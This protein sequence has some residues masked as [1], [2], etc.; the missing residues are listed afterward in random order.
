MYVELADIRAEGIDVATLS[1]AR[2][3]FLSEGWQAFIEARTGNWFESRTKTMLFDGDG[4]RLIHFPVPIISVTSL[5]VNDEFTTALD[6]TYYVVYNRYFPDDRKNP[7]IK[8][9]KSTDDF[10]SVSAGVFEVGDQ[11]QKVIGDFGYVEEGGSTP[12]MIERAIMTLIGMSMEYLS[13]G[14][15]DILRG[16]RVTEEVTDRH[17]VR[18]ANLYKEL[19]QWNSTGIADVDAAIQMYRRPAFIRSPRSPY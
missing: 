11:N 6:A 10:F 13:D 16:G 14:D 5:Y 3:T 8:L 15:L 9:K 2:A 7:R 18:F 12:F 4:S 19:G 17:R 1:D